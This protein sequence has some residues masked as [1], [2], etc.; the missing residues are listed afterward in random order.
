MVIFTPSRERKTFLL[1]CNLRFGIGDIS[2]ALLGYEIQLV[3]AAVEQ[4]RQ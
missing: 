1:F 3:L 4:R 2:I